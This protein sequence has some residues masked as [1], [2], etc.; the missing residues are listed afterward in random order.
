MAGASEPAAPPK[1]RP[2][3]LPPDVQDL[4]GRA[5][6][7]RQLDDLAPR[8]GT[9]V[10]TAVSGT[11]GVGKT[12]LA[13]HWAHRAADR[14]PDGLLYADLRGFDPGGAAADQREAVRAFLEALGVGP[15]DVPT[16][17]EARLGLYRTLLADKRVLVLLDNA[18]DAAHA[19][20]LIAGGTGSLVIVT[21][22]NRLTSLMTTNNAVPVVLDL[23][24]DDEARSLLAARLGQARVA[25]EPEAVTEVVRQCAH[26]P[27][28]LVLA[29]ARA[30]A[31]TLTLTAPAGEL[32]ESGGLD[33]LHVHD[34]DADVRSVFSWSY[35]LLSAPAARALRLHPAREFDLAS[36]A[37]A[38][39]EDPVATQRALRE[40]T[41][42]H[43]LTEDTA[44]RCSVHDLLRAYAA[45][46]CAQVDSPADGEAATRRPLD[47]YRNTAPAAD[48]IITPT[49]DH[50]ATPSPVPGVHLTPLDGGA[51]ALAWFAA[52]RSVLPAIAD[53]SPAAGLAD[54]VWQT[55]CSST[56]S[57]TAKA[58]A[59]TSTTPRRAHWRRR[60]AAG[61]SRAGRGRANA[62]PGEHPARTPRRGRG[63]PADGADP[64]PRARRR[65]PA[66][67]DL[68]E[69][70]TPG[71]P[72]AGP[73]GRAAPGA[74]SATRTSAISRG[75]PKR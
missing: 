41:G 59:W 48:R 8:A 30:A 61:T 64:A 45:D 67:P 58:T 21:S 72:P 6:H 57:S 19:R 71:H 34:D 4:A 17:S 24:T 12:T 54:H 47:H 26:L 37:S 75:A 39:A 31:S 23:L 27:L 44:G 62:W 74:P 38:L 53:L 56:R 25:A 63:T 29:A 2:H 65:G 43:L 32:R 3:Q 18:R 60:S 50:M 52:A 11:A 46:L 20:P 7:L 69:P 49:S 14:F 13:V 73:H 28:A 70:R 36:A 9:V 15:R 42:C 33:G 1:P 5:E 68:H 16:T 55:T 10:V 22:R 40:L 35:R 66:G 51:E